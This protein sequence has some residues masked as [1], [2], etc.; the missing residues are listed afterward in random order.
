MEGGSQETGARG[1]TVFLD[2]TEAP[3][4]DA[5]GARM[6]RSAQEHPVRRETEVSGRREDLKLLVDNIISVA[7][8]LGLVE[9]GVEAAATETHVLAD[10]KD[11]ERKHEEDGGQAGEQ[12]N[13]VEEEQEEEEEVEDKDQEEGEEEDDGDED[14][15]EEGDFQEEEEWEED[16]DEDEDEDVEDDFHEEEDD[17]EEQ[18]HKR[19]RRR[20]SRRRNRNRRIRS[21]R[22]RRGKKVKSRRS[23]GGGAGAAAAAA[24]A[25]GGLTKGA[26]REGG[27]SGAERLGGGWGRVKGSCGAGRGGAGATGFTRRAAGGRGKAGKGGEGRDG[28]GARRAGA[29]EQEKEEPKWKEQGGWCLANARELQVKQEEETQM[30]ASLHPFLS[31]LEALQTEVQPLNTHASREDSQLKPSIWQRRQRHLQQRSALIQGIRGFW[32]K[33][34]VNHPQ[35]SALISKPDESMLRHMTNLKVEEHKFPREC[36]KILLFFGKNSYFQNEVVTKE[37]VLGLAGHRAS[38]SSPI[39]WYPRYRQ[40]AYRRR[41]DNSSL[42]FFNWFSDHSFAGSSRIAE[43]IIEDLWPNPLPY[44][45]MKEAPGERT[46]RERREQP[47]VWALKYVPWGPWHNS[48]LHGGTET[49]SGTGGLS[50]VSNT[51]CETCEKTPKCKHQQALRVVASS[52]AACVPLPECQDKGCRSHIGNDGLVRP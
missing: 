24:G 28:A 2:A 33:A 29:E 3:H 27:G 4:D 43:I 6:P 5:V 44:F 31:L 46:E 22:R 35:M 34:F 52:Q 7:E 11:D 42:N 38:H 41:H 12:D 20:R 51:P 45:K 19:S 13:Y 26:E 15:D 47:R 30:S 10:E 9:E 49:H 16:D 40:E 50:P 39:Q 48:L 17:E 23:G 18:D 32:A 8:L 37:Y 25:A 14:E 21:K 1:H 36:R